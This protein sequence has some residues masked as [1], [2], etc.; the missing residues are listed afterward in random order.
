VVVVEAG[1]GTIG[2][3]EYEAALGADSIRGIGNN[4][5]FTYTFGTPF[6]SAPSVAVVTMA[7]VDG[8]NGGWAYTYGSTPLA[9]SNLDL[10]I[11]ED[12][13]NDS[14]R[15]HTPEQVGY[16]VFATSGVYP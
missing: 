11:D 2:G 14:E 8:G 3:V 5:P 9:A 1:H 12:Q 10:V 16:V 4:P 15:N 6:A 7:G 13:V